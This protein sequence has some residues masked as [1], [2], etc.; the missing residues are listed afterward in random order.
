MVLRYDDL[1]A[2]LVVYGGRFDAIV[3]P[4]K[5]LCTNVYDGNS[6]ISVLYILIS[7]DIW[8][9]KTGRISHKHSF[10]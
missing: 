2:H 1:R 8:M 6:R 10:P 7:W 5:C 3:Y 4:N 9:K